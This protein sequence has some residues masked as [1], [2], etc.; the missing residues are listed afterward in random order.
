M[1]EKGLLKEEYCFTDVSHANTQYASKLWKELE[2][3]L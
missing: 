3:T 1:D 2:N